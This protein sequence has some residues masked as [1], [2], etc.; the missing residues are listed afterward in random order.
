M[1][2]RDGRHYFDISQSDGKWHSYPVDYTIG[3]KFQQAY[4]TRLPNGEIHVFPIQ[5]NLLQRRWINFWKILD[6]PATERADPRTWKNSMGP[7]AIW[8][9]CSRLSHQPIENVT[10]EGFAPTAGIKELEN[11]LRDVSR[12]FGSARRRWRRTSFTQAAADPPVN[13][14]IGT[15][16][17][18]C[19]QCHEQSAIRK[20]AWRGNEL[21]GW[22]ISSSTM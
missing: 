11:W 8:S 3:S 22:E 16:C 9:A 19:A 13:F 18:I 4:A 5:Y 1:T 12:S 6:G 7:P 14:Q 20:P 21:P 2:I 15:I 10:G 17:R